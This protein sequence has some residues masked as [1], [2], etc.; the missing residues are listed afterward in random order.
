MLQKQELSPTGITI[1]SGNT[2][3]SDGHGGYMVPKRDLISNVQVLLQTDRL[4]LAKEMPDVD[5]LVEEL[6][7]FQVKITMS[8]NDTYEAWRHGS[9]DDMVLALALACWYGEEHCYRAPPQPGRKLLFHH[10]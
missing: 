3:N 10:I 2:V 7:H 5:R 1:T 6:L 8:G 4:K 9:H